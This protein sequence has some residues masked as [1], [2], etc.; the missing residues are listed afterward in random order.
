MDRLC[1]SEILEGLHLIF[2]VNHKSFVKVQGH[3]ILYRYPFFMIQPKQPSS[4]IKN[5]RLWFKFWETLCMCKKL[6]GVIDTRKSKMFS[7]IVFFSY[8]KK[9]FYD[10]NLW[11]EFDGS[12]F[13]A[14]QHFYVEV[15]ATEVISRWFLSLFKNS[16]WHH[17]H[18]GV[19]CRVHDTVSLQPLAKN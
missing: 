18:R 5:F 1:A 3:E 12:T 2:F 6:Q 9:R 17:S 19:R 7:V 4:N 8:L 14:L 16:N 13:H 15:Q 11:F 10:K